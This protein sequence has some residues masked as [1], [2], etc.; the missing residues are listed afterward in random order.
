MDILIK[1]K[2]PRTIER[3]S[4]YNKLLHLY[5]LTKPGPKLGGLG[6]EI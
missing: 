1:K 4:T 5:L 2:K 3:K 6:L